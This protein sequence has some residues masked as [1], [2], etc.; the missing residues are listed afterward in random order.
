MSARPK[1]HWDMGCEHYSNII[2]VWMKFYMG[3]FNP[4]KKNVKANP[5]GLL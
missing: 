4:L 3:N 2:G 5:E 1:T